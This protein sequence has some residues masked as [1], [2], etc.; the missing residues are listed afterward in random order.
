MHG[1]FFELQ[2]PTWHLLGVV[3]PGHVDLILAS[4]IRSNKTGKTSLPKS[5]RLLAG[6]CFRARRAL[7]VQNSD[8][9]RGVRGYDPFHRF[10]RRGS[11]ERDNIFARGNLRATLKTDNPPH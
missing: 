8:G 4:L 6:I 9:R 7:D 3:I 1:R 2:F 10:N 11:L 5:D